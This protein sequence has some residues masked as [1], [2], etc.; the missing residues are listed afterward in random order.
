MRKLFNL[1]LGGNETTSNIKEENAALSIFVCVC[2][3]E[4]MCVCVCFFFNLKQ[5]VKKNQP[6]N[7]CIKQ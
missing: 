6:K 2:V 5:R 3:C 1:S 7:L 4:T